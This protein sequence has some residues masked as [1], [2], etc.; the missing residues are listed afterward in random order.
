MNN[1]K[2][3]YPVFLGIICAFLLYFISNPQKLK[4][5]FNDYGIIKSYQSVLAKIGHKQKKPSSEVNAF[6]DDKETETAQNEAISYKEEKKQEDEATINLQDKTT[7]KKEN[8]PDRINVDELLQTDDEANLEEQEKKTPELVNKN[9]EKELDDYMKTLPESSV[10][11]DADYDFAEEDSTAQ[12]PDGA[13]KAQE[14]L[15]KTQKLSKDDFFSVIDPKDDK[16]ITKKSDEFLLDEEPQ[17]GDIDMSMTPPVVDDSKLLETT[18]EDDNRDKII[19]LDSDIKQL[20]KEMQND[21]ILP[22]NNALSDINID[23]KEEIEN[24]LEIQED[25]SDFMGKLALPDE[26]FDI[27]KSS[28]ENSKDNNNASQGIILK[29]KNFNCRYEHEINTIEE[30]ET[31]K[32]SLIPLVDNQKPII[33]QIKQKMEL[34]QYL[35]MDLENIDNYPSEFSVLRHF[36]KTMIVTKSVSED[37]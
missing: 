6:D 11:E 10:I 15:N 13:K 34:Y 7:L 23:K 21:E 1:K 20:E 12:N 9:A 2:I 4:K 24:P 22:H 32:L 35:N 17:E 36:C 25:N 8:E 18:N 3:I 29:D 33:M 5:I 19:P 27:S 26:L 14:E 37:F 31:F 16:E 30:S 28:E